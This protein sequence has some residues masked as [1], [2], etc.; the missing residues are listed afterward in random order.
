MIMYWISAVCHEADVI[1]EYFEEPKKTKKTD[2]RFKY[3]HG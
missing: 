2:R 1:E 3:N